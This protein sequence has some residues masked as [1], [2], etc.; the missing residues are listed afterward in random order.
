[1]LFVPYRTTRSAGDPIVIA[2][3]AVRRLGFEVARADA[4]RGLLVTHW[5]IETTMI[6][7]QRKRIELRFQPGPLPGFALAVPSQ[8]QEGDRWMYYGEDEE[9]RQRV[10]ATLQ[11]RMLADP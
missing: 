10:V 3:D 9:L 7:T 2:D 5:K 4:A 1:M 6:G 8:L 11:S